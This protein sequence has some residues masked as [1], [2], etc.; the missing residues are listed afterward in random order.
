MDNITAGVREREDANRTRVAGQLDEI[1]GVV[2]STL[3]GASGKRC[4][5][6][7]KAEGRNSGSERVNSFRNGASL[8]ANF[9][10]VGFIVWSDELSLL[11]IVKH[12]KNQPQW[13]KEYLDDDTDRMK[14]ADGEIMEQD[15][16]DV[17]FF[18]SQQPTCLRLSPNGDQRRIRSRQPRDR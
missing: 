2:A 3:N 11:L 15:I 8:L 16:A 12:D 6:D 18:V 13:P 4:D 5:I 1:Q 7:G 10:G 14:P 9:F 17:V